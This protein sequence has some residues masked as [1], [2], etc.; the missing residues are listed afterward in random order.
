VA[1]DGRVA[2][3]LIR[4]LGELPVVRTVMPLRF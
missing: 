2:P 1:V 3:D 4:Q